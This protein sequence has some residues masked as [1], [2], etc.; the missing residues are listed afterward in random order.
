MSKIDLV[1]YF[2]YHG[3]D[4][5]D[6]KM[7]DI[8]NRKDYEAFMEVYEVEKNVRLPEEAVLYI[9]ES[10]MNMPIVNKDVFV[11]LTHFECECD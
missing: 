1:Y 5:F 9:G 8:L 2:F 4:E 11:N 6:K 3:D 7:F 10:Y